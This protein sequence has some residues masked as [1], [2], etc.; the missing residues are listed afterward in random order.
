MEV[1][2]ELIVSN[3]DWD[4]CYLREILSVDFFEF[5]D[6]WDLDIKDG[7]LVVAME[8]V[9]K[10]TPITEDISLDDEVLCNVVE[11]IEYE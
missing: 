1:S 5:D 7:Q 2:D 9:E 4:P 8:Q 10:Y 11:K 6:H 3:R